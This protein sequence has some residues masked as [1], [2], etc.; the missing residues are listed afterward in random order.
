MQLNPIKTSFKKNETLNLQY[1][2]LNKGLREYKQ[3]KE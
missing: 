1:S 2:C 3:N